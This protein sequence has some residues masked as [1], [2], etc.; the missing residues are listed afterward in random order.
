MIYQDVNNNNGNNNGN[1]VVQQPVQPQQ[2]Q[3]NKVAISEPA[4]MVQQAAQQSFAMNNFFNGG[5][6][7][8]GR[9]ENPNVVNPPLVNAGESVPEQP[10]NPAPVTDEPSHAPSWEEMDN[11]A[12]DNVNNSNDGGGSSLSLSDVL[13]GG[14]GNASRDEKSQFVAEPEKKD[15]GFFKWIKG[16]LPKSRPGMREGETE[17]EYDR[18]RTRNMQ[19][20]ATL[21]DAIRHIGNIVNTSKGATQQKFNS[22][23]ELL[24]Q[25]YQQRKAERKKQAALD[26]DA[27]YKQAN[28]SLKEMAMMADKNH[29]DFEERMNLAN[30]RYKQGRDAVKDAHWNQ[31][32]DRMVGNDEFNHKLAT[33]NF[34]E[35]KR[36]HSVSENQG[37]QRLNLAATREAR[38]ATGGGSGKGSSKNDRFATPG[39]YMS[40]R[41]NLSGIEKKQLAQY[42]IR[43][44]Y[45]NEKN[46][47]SYRNLSMLDN[48]KGVN[49]LVNSWIGYAANTRGAKGIAF[50]NILKNNYGYSESSTVPK[51][52]TRRQV[53]N[54]K[55]P[56]P[57]N[58][59][60]SAGKG[61][62]SGFK[63]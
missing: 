55:Q 29:K 44:G 4:P 9:F 26:A 60:K 13:N 32:F 35:N 46:L 21:A 50:R 36:H 30:Y 28:L 47:E 22:P 49:D 43:H 53:T 27:A 33:D 6:R 59:K 54:N 16:L 63:L 1:G 5:N 24:E 31:N 48:S 11:M 17:D 58:S 18:R 8:V 40:R 38:M 61:W 45:I 7:A 10:K 14:S 62:A 52:P 39:G 42:L 12:Q 57:T 23:V 56:K 37:Q 15:G 51:L 2:Q 19:M 3:P 41:T 20:V 25:G 34:N